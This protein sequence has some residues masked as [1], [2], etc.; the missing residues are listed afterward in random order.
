MGKVDPSQGRTQLT[1]L[2]PMDAAAEMD[3]AI[4]AS[5]KTKRQWITDAIRDAVKKEN[6]RSGRGKT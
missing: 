1:V 6:R 3:A 2:I 4:E 5:G